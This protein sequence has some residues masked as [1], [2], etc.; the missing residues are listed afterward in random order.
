M[1][2]SNSKNCISDKDRYISF[3]DSKSLNVRSQYSTSWSQ[4]RSLTK[5]G[6]LWVGLKCDIR[7]KFCY[8]DN[9]NS[10]AK[11]WIPLEE[12][13]RALYKFRCFY[14]KQFVD[15]MGGEP[16]IYPN[17]LEIVQFCKEIGLAATCIT[18]GLHLDKRGK[19]ERFKDA[20]IHDFLMSV[21]GVDGVVDDILRV[22]KDNH[23]RQLKALINLRDLNIPV[24]FN[25][26]MIKENKKQLLKIAKLCNKM[27]GTVINFITFNPYFEWKGCE[28]IPFQVKHS[29]ISSYLKE[30]IDFCNDNGV[31]ANVRYMPLCMMKGYEKH[32]YNGFQLPYDPHE[33]DY[34]SWYDRGHYG[35]PNAEWYEEASRKQRL[36]YDYLYV[37]PCLRCSVKNI[38][39]GFHR[40]Y[41]ERWDES[42]ASPYE[43]EIITDPTHFI[44]KQWKL[45][46]LEEETQGIEKKVLQSCSTPLN[47]SQ[48]LSQKKNRAGI[49]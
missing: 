9:L 16:T 11:Q 45:T 14:K 27:G 29:E 25:V 32:L 43:G 7:C 17:I 39:D 49:F 24:R 23:K 4:N 15:L 28:N 44:R 34:N 22:G 42:E 48:F 12:G 46:Y 6:V 10:K 47:L 33:W 41:I 40:Q 3:A 30:T 26:T 1:V 35:Q 13:K 38:C 18:H 5:R 19:V 2:L 31:E 37:R 20:G 36:R 8:D 21:H